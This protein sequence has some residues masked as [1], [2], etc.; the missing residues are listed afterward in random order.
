MTRIEKEEILKLERMVESKQFYVDLKSINNWKNEEVELIAPLP[1]VSNIY[2]LSVLATV[3]EVLSRLLKNNCGV[4]IIFLLLT[5]RTKNS[6]YIR[7][8]IELHI[9]TIMDKE[10]IFTL[11]EDVRTTEFE[12]L[13]NIIL[14]SLAEIEDKKDGKKNTMKEMILSKVDY[15]NIV[16]YIEEHIP[17]VDVPTQKIEDAKQRI[18]APYLKDFLFESS[19]NSESLFV[20]LL[21]MINYFRNSEKKKILCINKD[22]KPAF[23]GSNPDHFVVLD[24]PN[25]INKKV[26]KRTGDMIPTFITATSKYINDT[27]D[28]EFLK[29]LGAKNISDEDLPS[30]FQYCI[31][32]YHF[33][34]LLSKLK[35]LLFKSGL[36]IHDMSKYEDDREKTLDLLKS[37]QP[38]ES[39]YVQIAPRL[40]EEMKKN[41]RELLE[42]I[43]DGF[44]SVQNNTMAELKY[45]L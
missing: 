40:F 36:S 33:S 10:D 2:V 7:D 42:L 18:E 12:S 35:S 20:Q 1:I 28:S 29:Q 6:S 25:P 16:T 13:I 11:T 5:E 27:G 4:K 37:E 22:I 21:S 23:D 38:S 45:L 3:S 8:A 9:K 39:E 14:I 30:N 34:G 15:F 31:D 19:T 24:Y 32:E 44:L 43:N 41:Q 26:I 17:K